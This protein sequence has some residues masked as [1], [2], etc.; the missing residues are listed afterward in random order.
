[1]WEDL[2]IVTASRPGGFFG[3][4]RQ[5]GTVRWSTAIEFVPPDFVLI[6]GLVYG[7]GIDRVYAL[8]AGDG[9]QVWTVPTPG[10]FFDWSLN[11]SPDGLCLFDASRQLWC[12][13]PRT[14]AVRWRHPP[15]VWGTPVPWAGRV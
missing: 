13:D 14:G 6:D 3:L 10:G 1:M 15:E 4:D 9:R 2:L 8:N 7:L 5:T 12:L 11:A